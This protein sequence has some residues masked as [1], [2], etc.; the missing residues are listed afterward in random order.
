MK[1]LKTD[2]FIQT[3]LSLDDY[4]TNLNFA[5]L[6]IPTVLDD[7]VCVNP[8]S[9]L[10]RLRFLK[11]NHFDS[12]HSLYLTGLL[13]KKIVSNIV[14][15]STLSFSGGLVSNVTDNGFTVALQGSLLNAYVLFIFTAW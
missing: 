3:T 12:S 13:G 11:T 7:S 14:D 1:N 6:N 8:S 15:Q 2:L 5:Q 4:V 10:R 9:Y